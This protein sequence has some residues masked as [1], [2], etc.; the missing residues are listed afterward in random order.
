[1]TL[2]KRY[3]SFALTA[4]VLFSGCQKKTINLIQFVNPLIGTG[5]ST[6]PNAL[7]HNQDS[8]AWGQDIPAVSTPF[9]MTQWT[10]QTRD[11]E[12]KCVSPYYYGG[13]KIQGFRGSH[14]LGGS[15]TQDYGSFTIMPITGYLKTFAS[16]RSSLY[17]HDIERSTPAYYSCVLQKY[18]TFVEI[19]GTARTGFFR[20]SYL[21]E[22]DAK[23]LITPNSDEGQGYIKVDPEKQEI[24]GYNPVHRIYQG[25][26]EPAGFNGYFVVRFNKSFD[27]FGCYFQMEDHKQETEI[28]GKTD[29]GAYVAFNIKKNDV[30]LAKAGTS[31]TS[32]EE[33]RANM[34]AEIPHWDFEKTKTETEE[35]W[36]ETLSAIQLKGGKDEDYTRFYTAMYHALLYPRTFS[37]VD[38]SYPA[39]DGNKSVQKVEKG[40]VYYD[41]FSMW[42][43]FRAQLP[44]VSLVAPDKYEDM[45]KSLVLKAEQGGWLP[46]FPAWNSYTSAMVGDH[47]NSA[48]G[49]AY[50]NG[51]D[52]NIDRAYPYM[53]KN[54]FEVSEGE[55]YRNGKGR[56]GMKS[57]LEYGYIPL[58]DS[59]KEA[60]HKNEQVSRTLEY[61]MTDAILSKVAAK[62]GK[63]DDAAI[64]AKRGK[65]YQLVFDDETKSMRGRFIDGTWSKDYNPYARATYLTEG[66]PMQHVWFV[67]QD[68]PGL[69]D[70]IGDKKQVQEKLDEL[71]STGEYW[72]SN[73]PCH[74]IPY[75]Y[76]YLGE[77]VETQ[78]TVKNI[79]ATEYTNF[80][81]GIPGND[82]AG[83]MSAWYVFSAMGFYPVSI[84]SG[85]YQLSSPIFNEV[86]LNLNPK[87]YP[88]EKFTISLGD[89]DTYKTFNY[90]EL[91]GKEIPF[92]IRHEDLRKGGKLKFSNSEK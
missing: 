12:N 54:A 42:D 3:L 29:I 53:R 86:E 21:N 28:S 39:F 66:T 70:L 37:D 1:M 44:L 8:E 55:D 5:P 74:H 15:C 79:L 61:S 11:T 91:D 71:F 78:K 57:Y 4:I 41:D 83:Q 19:T 6:G 62:Y 36:N 33:A 10:P 17:S 65:N 75:L 50:L 20:F 89:P 22:A 60:F 30:V 31:F 25:W 2:S 16:E 38:G 35:I 40:H 81:G 56:R 92:M 32:L 59:V 63:P 46:I 49:D 51:F 73:E 88:G 47:V 23:I 64:L 80:D 14:W 87:Y 90:A 68:L 58:E 69:F 24:Y 9:G 45:M 77:P 26:G 18:M 85:E 48:L 82:D 76:N 7:K 13:T 84:G 43:T 27:N 67:P 72:H 34:D 52:I